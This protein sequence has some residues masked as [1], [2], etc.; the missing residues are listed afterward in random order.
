MIITNETAAPP[1]G[2]DTILA[3]VEIT[4]AERKR[5]QSA[6]QK[7]ADAWQISDAY[8][9]P[10]RAERLGRTSPASMVATAAAEAYRAD[11]S[12]ANAE[13]YH[14][15]ILF[16]EDL[17]KTFPSITQNVQAAVANI[18]AGLADL[19]GSIGDRALAILETAAKTHRAGLEKSDV[20]FGVGNQI[21]E[22]NDRLFS[23]R[24]C[25]AGEI[26][27]AKRDPLDFLTRREIGVETARE[28][29]PVELLADPD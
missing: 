6:R 2:L 10:S 1:L 14:K 26:A 3:S 16:C 23:T 19:I 4:P 25:L 27:E 12:A 28:K 17:E 7:V 24:N 29:L 21:R 9:S 20:I 18:S 8:L 5:I 22:F 15:A 11:P 13:A